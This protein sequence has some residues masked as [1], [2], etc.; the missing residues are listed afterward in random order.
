[1][2]KIVRPA[3]WRAAQSKRIFTH[4]IAQSTQA[5]DGAPTRQLKGDGAWLKPS[6][7]RLDFLVKVFLPP[8]QD[9]V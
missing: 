3:G 7:I 6:Q 4:K 2:M 8:F 5:S 1:M 9:L